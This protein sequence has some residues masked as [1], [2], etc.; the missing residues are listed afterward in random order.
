LGAVS[1]PIG[2]PAPPLSAEEI[3][4]NPT[5]QFDRITSGKPVTDG[6]YHVYD[7]GAYD[8]SHANIVVWVGTTTGDMFV[9][10][11]IFVREELPEGQGPW[12]ASAQAAYTK[13]HNEKNYVD[14]R[15]Y[16]DGIDFTASERLK[17]EYVSYQ[18]SLDRAEGKKAS[19]VNTAKAQAGA[20]I[21][22]IG[23]GDPSW[24]HYN[25]LSHLFDSLADK[26]PAYYYYKS[27]EVPDVSSL[28]VIAT[29]R[30]AVRACVALNKLEEAKAISIAIGDSK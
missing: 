28:P 3:D 23:L 7:F 14:A 18:L 15:T 30:Y 10:R 20:Y 5:I 11:F 4:A 6:E 2:K 16:L 22:K 29:Q 24:I 12:D 1:F 19:S 25:V 27:I 13:L 21:T 17:G 26:Q 8:L 9:E